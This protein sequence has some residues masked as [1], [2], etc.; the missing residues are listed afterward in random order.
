MR[1]L[2]GRNNEHGLDMLFVVGNPASGA[3]SCPALLL[4]AALS[5]NERLHRLVWCVGLEEQT[6]GLGRRI[7]Q[8]IMTNQPHSGSSAATQV[9]EEPVSAWQ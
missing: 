1:A 8:G 2:I 5:I 7:G 6:L 9:P 3:G 4:S